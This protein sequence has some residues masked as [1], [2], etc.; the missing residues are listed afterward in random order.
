MEMCKA[1]YEGMK[2]N[3]LYIVI[4]AYNENETIE[5]VI[6]QWYTIVEKVGEDSRLVIIDDG[7]KDNTYE[8]VKKC[9][10]TRKQLIPLTKEN[11]GHGATVLFAYHYAI[12]QGA[13]YIFQT[14]SD[15]QTLPEEFWNLWEQRES[16]DMLIGNRSNRKDGI[17]R[18]FVTKVLK[19]VIKVCFRVN[20]TDANTPFRLMKA[21]VLEENLTLVPKDFNLSNVLISVIYAKKNLKVKYVPITFR[22]RQ[23]GKNSINLRKIFKIGLKAV[24]DFSTINKQLKNN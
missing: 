5:T 24:Q 21:D 12:Q 22:Q 3:K 11:S 15:G 20:V 17:S 2:M 1:K 10:E 6:E 9:A 18:V 13:D 4:P 14:D 7:S 23:G 8:I 19:L 16:Y